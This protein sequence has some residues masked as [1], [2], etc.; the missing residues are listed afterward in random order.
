MVVIKMK[1]KI[2][3]SI[4]IIL[5]VGAVGAGA[6]FGDSCDV[7]I[8]PGHGGKD[9]GAIYETRNEKDDNLNLA[10]LVYE[11]LEEM[12][13]DA[14]LTRDKDKKISLEK[15]CAYANRKR[16]KLFVSLHRNSAEGAKGV[17]IWV[18]ENELKNTEKD[19]NLADDILRN[20]DEAGISKNR[21]VKE[22]YAQGDG[23]YY[24]NT[25]TVMPSCLVELG[26]IN[27]ETDN[28]LYDEKLEEYAQAIAQ[29]IADN[30]KT[31]EAQ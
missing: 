8:D 29:A 2:I 20:L 9:Y 18:E 1:R 22:G 7:V 27:S 14:E 26:F 3:I 25:Y 6:Y 19:R 4:C 16:A 17:E 5:A 11:K 12:G 15:R 10:L 30:L 24:V 13:I 23:N 28:E 21:G 31:A